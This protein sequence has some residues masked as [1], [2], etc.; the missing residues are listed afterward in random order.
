MGP[1]GQLFPTAT[2]VSGLARRKLA[3]AIC[4]V[5]AAKIAGSF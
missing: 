5:V 3:L 4:S 1:S 2:G